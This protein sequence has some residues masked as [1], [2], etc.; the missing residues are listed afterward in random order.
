MLQIPRA[1]RPMCNSSSRVHSI[2]QGMGIGYLSRAV[3]YRAPLGMNRR[4]KVEGIR[5][6]DDTSNKATEQIASN[7]EGG[8]VLFVI[9]RSLSI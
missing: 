1:Q 8:S 7:G 5:A 4:E 2:A 3:R 9:L 6:R